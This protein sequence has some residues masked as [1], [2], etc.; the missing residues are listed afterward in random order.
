MHNPIIIRADG[1]VRLNPQQKRGVPRGTSPVVSPSAQYSVPCVAG[2]DADAFRDS[3]Y[4]VVH[5]FQ[6]LPL[7]VRYIIWIQFHSGCRINEVLA[8]TRNDCNVN[9]IIKLKASKWGLAR[10]VNIPL[11]NNVP[12][13][14]ISGMGLIFADYDRFFIYRLCKARGIYFRKGNLKVNSVTHSFRAAYAASILEVSEQSQDTARAMGHKSS[15]T[16]E[17]YAK[18]RK[19]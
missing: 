10:I 11:L 12:I 15:K 9:N 5:D 8:L 14:K 19:K 1:I 18:S 2:F 4:A 3:V 16:I 6:T 13:C 7:A 17:Y